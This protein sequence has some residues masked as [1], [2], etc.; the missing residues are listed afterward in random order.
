MHS[1]VR[2]A[3]DAVS[4]GLLLVAWFMLPF[5]AALGASD[6]DEFKVKR[7]AVFE[8]A[9]KPTVVRN[10]DR[11]TIT[12]ETKA[13]CDATVA[14]EDE[15]GKIVRHLASGV[16]GPKAPAPFRKD[17]KKQTIIWDG[18]NDHGVYIDDKDALTIRVSLGLSPR[19][20]RTLFWVPKRRG[21][22]ARP[23]MGAAPEGVY[24]YNGGS[25]IDS[26]ILYS[27]DGDYLRTVYPFPG[28]K[29][30]ST[31]GLAWTTYPQDGKRVPLKANFLQCTMLT[32]GTNGGFHAAYRGVDPGHPTARL[33]E[34]HWGM[35]GKAA[36]A[37]D[38]RSGR[39]A[40]VYRFVNRV[41]TDGTTASLPLHGSRAAIRLSKDR[42]ASPY[43][44]ALSPD[45]KWLYTTGY[46]FGRIRRATQDIQ[47]L[48]HVETIPVVL[49]MSMETA[50][51]PT[52]FKG[53][54]KV[55]GAGNGRDQFK[56]PTAVDVDTQGRVY[57]AD[58]INDRVQVYG[59]DGG[60]LKTI[61]TSR[62][63]HVAVHRR[64]GHIYT[65][66]WWV[67]NQHEDT[68]VDRQIIHLGPFDN[69]KEVERVD[70]AP[71]GR[72]ATS[73]GA[74]CPVEFVAEIDDWSAPLRVW[75]AEPWTG[76]S[77]LSRGKIKQSS[78][79]VREWRDG[80]LRTVRDFA[81]DVRRQRAPVKAPVYY[82]QRL[83]VNPA[84]GRAYVSEG[85]NSAVGKSFRD[86]YEID[87]ATGRVR[88][89]QL[90]FDAED[91]CFD[92]KGRVYLRT[93]NV[94]VRYDW[95]TWKEVP[96]DYGTDRRRVGFGWMSSTRT[97]DAV[98]G[99]VMPADG[100]WHHGGMYIAANG[101]IA[102]ACGLNI[103]MQV[104]TSAKYVH[105]GKKYTPTVYP[106]R[107]MEGR[108]GATTLHI[109]DDRGRLVREDVVPGLSDLY[110]IGLHGD[111]D[112]YLMSSATRMFGGTPYLNAMTGT[113]AKFPGSNGR[114]LTKRGAKVPLPEKGY[115]QRPVDVSSGPQGP[116]W[117]TGAEWFFGGV[118]YSG[119]NG[120]GCAC[121][122]ARFDL[123]RFA[124]SFAPEV[125]RYSIAVL[126]RAGNVITRIGRYG[127]VDDG[128][129]IV[130]RGGP[131][132]PQSIGGDE[133]ALYHA[134]YL[135]TH[136]DR[137]LFIA[138]PGN[139]RI[140]SVEL[141]YHATERVALKDVQEGGL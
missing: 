70:L 49:R 68:H 83:Y 88:L 127:N 80:A 110:G 81:K 3:R 41:G 31:K 138:D 116:A 130:E 53:S 24:V 141:S 64:T 128:K 60:Y 85:S 101:H 92:L 5:G 102:V 12:F 93:V 67:R 89:V 99:L 98:S 62:P 79:Q 16:L 74:N 18:K 90:P 122:N 45:G 111:D 13:F 40:L 46:H 51:E 56:V 7:E 95:A 118:G 135:A 48:E 96:W 38:V 131:E 86:L 19:F 73:W 21:G 43:S 139:A 126:D 11:V 14:I 37:M 1:R 17:S 34:A 91:M 119:R 94:L 29:I 120:G 124:R 26:V 75:L 42:F 33:K 47:R 8:F 22:D 106:G 129:P 109:W 115:P 27:R 104:R 63:A 105:R 6:L 72:F 113:L 107:L 15:K 132:N 87:P 134:P 123:D 35:Y 52:V 65:F 137:R 103:S 32:S 69:P 2:F 36:N 28:E 10:G 82:R 84:N 121:W 78:I 25:A 44:A 97:T 59:P 61:N 23:L 112:L 77:V 108:A 136:T 71:Q 57:V 133:V 50:E 9:Q 39:I 66:S 4:A 76:A 20:E 114:V 30:G 54:L 58:Y 100:N 55:S 117:F 140:V 125:D